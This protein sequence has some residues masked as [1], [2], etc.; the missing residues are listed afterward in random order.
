MQKITTL[1]KE[2]KISY[3]KE[4]FEDFITLLEEF[5]DLRNSNEPNFFE[6]QENKA[7]L[8]SQNDSFYQNLSFRYVEDSSI[9]SIFQ[10]I[11]W[12]PIFLNYFEEK[13]YLKFLNFCLRIAE[14][15]DV[16]N[17]IQGLIYMSKSDFDK[18][19]LSLE[20]SQLAISEYYLA[21]SYSIIYS[22]QNAIYK[23]LEFENLYKSDISMIETTVGNKTKFTDIDT[24]FGIEL[25]EQDLNIELGYCYNQNEEYNK[26]V[27]RFELAFN[28]I[29]LEMYIQ[30]TQSLSNDFK[31]QYTKVIIKN[32]L[33]S[34]YKTK[35]S[36]KGLEICKILRV[37]IPDF[38][39]LNYYESRFHQFITT[40]NTPSQISDE[41]KPKEGIGISIKKETKEIS[42]ELHLE[43]MILDHIKNGFKV[44]NKSLDVFDDGK[45]YG[46]QLGVGSAGILDLLLIENETKQLYVVELKRGEGNNK[47]VEQ[48]RRY[49][50]AVKE[51]LNQNVKGIICVFGAKD[52]LKIEVSKDDNIELFRYELNFIQE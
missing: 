42:K 14:E 45:R 11:F 21:K 19:I 37:N 26:S 52:D 1:L 49:M 10:F 51:M 25:L 44:F 13:I 17:F 32:Y 5:E 12:E 16:K 47:V 4:K 6:N 40:S 15:G 39:G 29:N 27:S 2:L 18:A 46:K 41:F 36:L 43:N 7:L 30:D 22:F 24:N 33:N 8:N 38:D 35:N 34:L 9:G 50:T 31:S 23:Y 28:L 48:T 3:N 20:K